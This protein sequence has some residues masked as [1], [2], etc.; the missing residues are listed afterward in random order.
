M[1]LL[2]SPYI[3]FIP[4]HRSSLLCNTSHQL[5][6]L[7]YMIQICLLHSEVLSEFDMNPLLILHVA[8]LLPQHLKGVS[9]TETEELFLGVTPEARMYHCR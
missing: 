8:T 3:S 1:V 2:T 4:S 6:Y 9:F 5:N 7:M